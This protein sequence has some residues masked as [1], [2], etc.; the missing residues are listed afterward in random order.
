MQ[1]V[2][3]SHSQ[4]KLLIMEYRRRIKTIQIIILIGL[5]LGYCTV[6]AQPAFLRTDTLGHS[7]TIFHANMGY[8]FGASKLGS[9]A[10]K[11]IDDTGNVG[12]TYALRWT[13]CSNKNSLGY[14]M[15]AL[16]YTDNKKHHPTKET[17]LKEKTYITYIAP[18]ISYIKK[19]TA[20]PNGFGLIDF[21]IGYLH[22]SSES[23]LPEGGTY[24]VQYNGIALN[25]GISYEYPFH[26][27]WGAKLEIGSIFSPIRPKSHSTISN[28]P[29]QP[30]DKINLFLI[31]MQIG[32][33][34]YL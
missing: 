2:N 1:I 3:S 21:G 17:T 24:Q 5:L 12:L 15:Y 20:F 26:K 31:F 32:I 22:Y 18:Q 30:R 7:T 10:W 11:G 34:H 6:H 4:T 14:G 25:A 16:G 9:S 29:L 27:N 33:S 8:G 28:L 23:K 19:E 13:H